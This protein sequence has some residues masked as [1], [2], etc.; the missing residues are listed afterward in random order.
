MCVD[1]PRPPQCRAARLWKVFKGHFLKPPARVFLFVS[2]LLCV[3]TLSL[4]SLT[5]AP[6]QHTPVSIATNVLHRDNCALR[7]SDP[8]FPSESPHYARL[9]KRGCCRRLKRPTMTR[10][11]LLYY[12]PFLSYYLRRQLP[13]VRLVLRA[14]K[15]AQRVSNINNA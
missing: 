4:H 11:R 2:P 13:P 12:L 14:T 1:K 7:Y 6:K 3:M 9:G 10:C 5:C 8:L 15:A